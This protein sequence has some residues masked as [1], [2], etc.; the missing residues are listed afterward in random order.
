M[1]RAAIDD[2]ATKR[3]DERFMIGL[4]APA[5]APL[6]DFGGALDAGANADVRRAAAQVAAHRAVDVGV[7][8]CAL[9]LSS[10]AAVMIW[11]A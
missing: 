8:G 11:P 5:V 7:V 1:N 2:A 9:R 4:P 10:A 3:T 6:R